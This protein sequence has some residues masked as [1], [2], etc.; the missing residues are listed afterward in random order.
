MWGD[1]KM[2]KYSQENLNLC[3]GGKKQTCK[4]YTETEWYQ[5]VEILFSGLGV[6][7]NLLATQI[8][9]D[10]M[11]LEKVFTIVMDLKFVE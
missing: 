6:Q 3:I 1:Q 8:G 10:F 2:K 4:S 7:N 5:W 9:D 11:I